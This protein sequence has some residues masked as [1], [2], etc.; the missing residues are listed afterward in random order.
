MTFDPTIAYPPAE[1]PRILNPAVIERLGHIRHAVFDFDG[2]LS[3]IREGWAG[4]ITAVL[5]EARSL[6]LETFFREHIYGAEEV[7]EVD[8]KERIIR[9]ILAEN[10]LSGAEL[11]VVG[12]IPVEI[13]EAL[14]CGAITL[15]VA[16]DEVKRSGWDE[17]KVSRLAKAGPDLP[18]ADFGCWDSLLAFLNPGAHND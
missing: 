5:D 13:R 15:G 11:M 9:H 16:S 14:K 2:T 8:Q 7:S 17:H 4:A 1:G 6:G 12:D 3:V 10:H 18:V